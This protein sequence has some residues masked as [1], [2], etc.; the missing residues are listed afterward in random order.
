[1]N[2]PCPPFRSGIYIES[3]H[4]FAASTNAEGKPTSEPDTDGGPLQWRS[5]NQTLRSSTRYQVPSER[6]LKF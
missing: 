4:P 1:M 2:H 3:P 6:I 5:I